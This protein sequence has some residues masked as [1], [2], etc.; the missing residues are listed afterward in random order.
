M[1]PEKE[2]LEKKIADL[3]DAIKEHEAM[4]QAIIDKL[5][6]DITTYDKCSLRIELRKHT[7]WL[8]TLR[9]IHAKRH[10][11]FFT[12][13]LPEF[14][15]KSKECNAEWGRMWEQSR[16]LDKSQKNTPT[17]QKIRELIETY[18]DANPD[19]RQDIKNQYYFSLKQQVYKQMKGKYRK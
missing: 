19:N 8:E 6:L 13:Y 7:S 17:M 10:N 5:A 1:K 15:A 12:H 11:Y 18:P 14:E 4:I 2:I 16:E 9:D 3:L